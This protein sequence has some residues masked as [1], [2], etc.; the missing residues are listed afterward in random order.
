VLREGLSRPLAEG[1]AVEARGFGRCAETEDFR[2]GMQTFLE[3]GPRA[4]AA[5]VHR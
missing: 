5:F 3:Q 1:L 2:I 4:K